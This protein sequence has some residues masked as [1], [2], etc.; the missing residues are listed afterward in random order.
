VCGQE[1]ASHNYENAACPKEGG[2]FWKRKVY[3]PKQRKG[4]GAMS[5]AERTRIATL[6]GK[7]ISRNRQHMAAI[8]SRG[9]QAHVRSYRRLLK[10]ARGG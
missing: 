3:T 9:G 4:F 2:G 6:G 8:G 5:R 10:K 7:A 1:W